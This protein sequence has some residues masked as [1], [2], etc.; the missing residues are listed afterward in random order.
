MTNTTHADS[1][2]RGSLFRAAPLPEGP[3]PAGAWPERADL[4]RVQSEAL[5]KLM[6]EDLS[7]GRGLVFLLCAG[8]A[9]L[10]AVLVPVLLA[11]AASSDSDDFAVSVAGCLL[12]VIVALPALLVL[13]SLRARGLRR[14]RLLREW[15]AADRGHDS[16]IPSGYGS[17][18]SPH[19]R[20]FNAAAILVVAFVLAVV[21]SANV[22]DADALVM[23]PGLAVGASFA[24]ATVRKYADRYSWASRENVMRGRARRR[25][26]HRT[27]MSG[28]VEV[29]RAGVGPLLLYVAL[30]APVTIVAVVFVIVRPENVLGLVP[31][32]LIALAVLV[33]GLP[34]TALRR[35][36]ERKRLARAVGSLAAEFPP[37]A[38]VHPVRY[39]L[40]EPTEHHLADGPAAWD[41]GPSRAGVLAIGAGALQ[42]RGA[43]GSAL[44]IPL[45]ELVCVVCIA[46]TV[47]W[48]DPTVD[49]L[50]HSGYSVE[51]RTARAQEVAETL[52]GAG[53]RTVSV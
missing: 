41:C 15:A 7:R 20:F 47:N 11:D 30:C 29:Q 48:L 4:L 33:V 23:L 18:G 40:G 8:L 49:L 24:W 53:V 32:G 38:V 42:L 39:G 13:R 31:V 35:S 52:S 44:D 6:R 36:R 43:D 50:L 26:Q 25:H 10:V 14:R 45:T 34:M 12:L 5:R 17:Q 28:G 3:G 46:N 37:G 22:S 19:S 9:T 27:Q 2:P 1:S 51:L 16:E 21:V